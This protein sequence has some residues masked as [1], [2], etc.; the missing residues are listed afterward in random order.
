VASCTFFLRSSNKDTPEDMISTASASD[1]ELLTSSWKQQHSPVSPFPNRA[2]SLAHCNPGAEAE[3]DSRSIIQ[4]S[5]DQYQATQDQE[6]TPSGAAMPL[7][8]ISTPA[9]TVAAAAATTAY[10]TRAPEPAYHWGSATCAGSS[11]TTLQ[12]MWQMGTLS[13]SAPR[14]HSSSLPLIE[15]E[16]GS[17]H[18]PTHSGTSH[19]RSS[20]WNH[21]PRLNTTSHLGG[22]ESL[23][24]DS[25]LHSVSDWVHDSLSAASSAYCQASANSHENSRALESPQLATFGVVPRMAPAPSTPGM[26]AAATSPIYQP[27]PSLA[28]DLAEWY[29]PL[30]RSRSS[31]PARSSSHL[32]TPS[33]MMPKR[34]PCD[35]ASVRADPCP[36]NAFKITSEI[37][38]RSRNGEATLDIYYPQSLFSIFDNKDAVTIPSLLACSSPPDQDFETEDVDLR[39]RQQPEKRRSNDD[40]Y[41][42][43]WVR[44]EGTRRE[45][46]CSLCEPGSWMQLKQ[47]AYWYHMRTCHGVNTATGRIYSPPLQLRVQ[48]DSFSTTHGL[49]GRC[50][51]WQPI[52][53]ARRKRNFSAWFRHASSCHFTGQSNIA[54]PA[55]I[56]NDSKDGIVSHAASP[57]A[58]STPLVRMQVPSHVSTKR[59]REDSPA[60]SSTA[61]TFGDGPSSD[62]PIKRARSS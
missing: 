45:A 14:S 17:N 28:A 49:C 2:A 33:P 29:S 8:E 11:F 31:L 24:L 6:D 37:V 25:S 22:G 51:Q 46:W 41:T 61:S 35:A 19:H 20:S 13:E 50:S 15:F 55:S 1:L 4:Q 30:W 40:L 18:T 44:G 9:S 47:S 62:Y 52:C 38:L 42:P 12:S 57:T 7:L 43:I 32:T 10:T 34:R 21:F 27:S 23:G 3:P 16:A 26:T 48:N 60:L 58:T 56:D 5:L 54:A 59:E 36:K 53:T 39:P